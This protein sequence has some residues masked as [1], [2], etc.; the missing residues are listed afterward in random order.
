MEPKKHLQKEK[1]AKRLTM[2]SASAISMLA[3]NAESYAQIVYSANDGTVLS[4]DGQE[5]LIDLNADGVDD[6]KISV[7]EFKFKTKKGDCTIWDN[8]T[9]FILEG[10]QAS[11]Q[12]NATEF[13]KSFGENESLDSDLTGYW[14][15]SEDLFN[16]RFYGREC[17]MGMPSLNFKNN[18]NFW[19]S[20]NE[21][22]AVK[23]NKK[24]VAFYGWI[25]ISVPSSANKLTVMNWA[26]EKTPEKG[27]KTGYQN[28]IPVLS[29]LKK[30]YNGQFDVSLKFDSKIKGTTLEY[31]DFNVNNC[32]IHNIQ[33][34]DGD[35]YTHTLT[36]LPT[37]DNGQVWVAL[38]G[39]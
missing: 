9:K 3:L 39:S 16:K 10:L 28:P 5:K 32:V 4:S 15:Q 18:G 29:S 8:T 13:V 2:Y 25:R 7:K 36:I 27:I 34:F 38:K 26:C 23:F 6:F 19:N 20:D 31:S 35:D 11:N 22:I 17:L 37:I 1:L 30:N 21:Y 14:K 12:A 33:K 24:G